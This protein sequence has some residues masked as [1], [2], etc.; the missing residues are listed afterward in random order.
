LDLETKRRQLFGE[1]IESAGVG[2][3]AGDVRW[4]C[5]E[6]HRGYR[7]ALHVAVGQKTLRASKVNTSP[8]AEQVPCHIK[9]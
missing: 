9:K 6:D 5:Y 7:Q 8:H 1:V 2:G 4:G 3:V